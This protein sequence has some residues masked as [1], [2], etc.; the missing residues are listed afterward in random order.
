MEDWSRSRSPRWV[1]DLL[2]RTEEPSDTLTGVLGGSVR[3][4]RYTRLGGHADV[5]LNATDHAKINYFSDRIRITYDP[6]SPG[7]PSIPMGVYVFDSPS[8]FYGYTTEHKCGLLP[9]T[10][11]IDR[12]SVTNTYSLAKGSAIIPEVVALIE[13]TGESSIAVTDSDATTSVDL[14]F[15]AGESKLTIINELLAAANYSALW[16]DG[17]GQFRVE[18]YV[19]PS[20]RPIKYV[21]EPGKASIHKPVWSRSQDILSVPNRVVVLSPGTGEDPPIIGV[22][23][24]TDPDSPYSIPNRGVISRQEQVSD[25]ADANAATSHAEMLLHEG[26]TPVA[27]LEV[28]HAIVPL[29]PGD[30]VRFTSR[31]DR[32]ATV[33]E[34]NFSFDFDSQ[35]EAL[36]REL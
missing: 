33:R 27:T 9:K 24:N 2:D 19:E 32:L 17:S 28:E 25:M 36:W 16:V 20:K 31:G 30:L 10:A 4:A 34:M 7:L 35:C 18:P 5:R 8:D 26:M 13:S 23:E 1:V 22:A 3:I 29:E 21:F 6:G 12:D 11:I 14:A 15:D